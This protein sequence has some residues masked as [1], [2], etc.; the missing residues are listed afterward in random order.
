MHPL[1]KMLF[2][3]LFLTAASFAQE[4]TPIQK[5][6]I[7][8]FGDVRISR[9]T[10]TMF[11]HESN[12]NSI[13]LSPGLFYFLNRYVAV[14]GQVDVITFTGKG[15]GH[16]TKGHSL[17]IGPGVIVSYPLTDALAPFLKAVYQYE[18]SWAESNDTKKSVVVLTAGVSCFLNRHVALAPYISYQI[19]RTSYDA[20]PPAEP[21]DSDYSC[22]TAGIS[23]SV[24]INN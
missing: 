2:P 6:T 23:I 4:N 14:G 9:S 20:E 16:T 1:K 12:L 3:M 18:K 7:N 13:R 15:S 8:I 22:L 17:G 19:A 5:G 21:Y 11:G 10:N 24:F